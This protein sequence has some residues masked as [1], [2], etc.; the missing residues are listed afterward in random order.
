MAKKQTAQGMGLPSAKGNK[1]DNT[2]VVRR[3]HQGGGK[4][5]IDKKGHLKPGSA[6]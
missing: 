3:H 5:K 2:K 4:A 6:K 1:G